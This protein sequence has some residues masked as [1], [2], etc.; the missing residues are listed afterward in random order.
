MHLGHKL[1]L[2]NIC[3]LSFKMCDT[4]L[5]FVIKGQKAVTIPMSL[6]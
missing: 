6:L 3:A 5:L 1:V 2:I 4:H